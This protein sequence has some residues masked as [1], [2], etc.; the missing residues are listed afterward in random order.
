MNK[1]ATYQSCVT[2]A[3]PLSSIKGSELEAVAGT[4]FMTQTDLFSSR[5]AVFNPPYLVL[6]SITLRIMLN[7]G[8]GSSS[9][10]LFG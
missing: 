3:K 5:R 10:G 9:P 8:N 6:M 7:G 1:K 2:P 4:T